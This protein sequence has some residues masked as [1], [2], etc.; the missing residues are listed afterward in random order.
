MGFGGVGSSISSPRSRRRGSNFVVCISSLAVISMLSRVG[1]RELVQ[2]HRSNGA[3][4][5]GISQSITDPVKSKQQDDQCHGWRKRDIRGEGER[6][7]TV[8]NHSAPGWSRWRN[9][10]SQE[11]HKGF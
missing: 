1:R 9:A 3:W 6:L 2:S 8:G 10:E 7:I 11:T 5:E 4:I